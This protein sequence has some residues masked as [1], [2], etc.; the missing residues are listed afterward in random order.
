VIVQRD[1][2]L[3]VGRRRGA[4][5]AGTWALPGGMLEFGESVFDCAARE[6]QEECGLSIRALS[7]GPWVSTVFA[8]DGLHHVTLFVVAHAEPGE[9]TV[10]EP[11]KCEEWRWVFWHGLPEPLFAPLAALRD[12]GY[13]PGR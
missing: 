8:D 7:P 6:V 3:L 9:A 4:H 1:N 2:Q 10:C 12:S 5:G 13:S 11:H